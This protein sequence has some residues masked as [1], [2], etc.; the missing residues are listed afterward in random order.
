M[1]PPTHRSHRESLGNMGAWKEPGCR[2]G[3]GRVRWTPLRTPVGDPLIR[4][5][6]SYLFQASP[7][8]GTSLVWKWQLRVVGRKE[9]EADRGP[10]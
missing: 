5:E 9:G 4:L 7:E 3:S 2:P 1:G 10:G 6:F 8:V